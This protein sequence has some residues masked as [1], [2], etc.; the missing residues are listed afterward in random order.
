MNRRSNNINP[1]PRARALSSQWT[2]RFRLVVLI[3]CGIFM[4]QK[5]EVIAPPRYT[6]NLAPGVNEHILLHVI[7]I[8]F[9]L[10]ASSAFVTV[11]FPLWAC[12]AYNRV[13]IRL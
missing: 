6:G 12:Y 5:S 13:R 1:S 9:G 10:L 2:C 3:H 11:G 7:I 4:G 8:Q